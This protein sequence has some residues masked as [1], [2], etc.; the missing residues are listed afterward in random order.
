MNLW[1]KW[2]SNFGNGKLRTEKQTKTYKTPHSQP[3]AILN[4]FQIGITNMKKTERKKTN[5]YDQ[6]L[7]LVKRNVN[8]EV[9]SHLNVI[10]C[11]TTI[12]YAV[13]VCVCAFLFT[14]HWR[15]FVCEGNMIRM[16]KMNVRA[17]EIAHRMTVGKIAWQMFFSAAF[18]WSC[19]CVL[20]CVW[21]HY[22]LD[23]SSPII[24]TWVAWFR[25]RKKIIM[26]WL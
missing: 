16:R 4:L 2:P 13:C 26:F 8:W 19:M 24:F 17:T 25:K 3:V 23:I 6:C 20:F 15:I 22:I 14:L 12:V 21:F 7:C 9:L 5:Q 10:M 18:A 11:I 1:I